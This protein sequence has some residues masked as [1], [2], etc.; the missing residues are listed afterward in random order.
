MSELSDTQKKLPVAMSD[1]QEALATVKGY[2]DHAVELLVKR[3]A[4]LESRP[5][6]KYLGIW[7]RDL[8]YTEGNFVSYDGAMWHAACD[9]K[10]VRPGDGGQCWKLAVKQGRD[11]K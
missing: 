6:L 2:I 1:M 9:S 7:S 3:V 11:G 5:T 4:E 8:P 10:G